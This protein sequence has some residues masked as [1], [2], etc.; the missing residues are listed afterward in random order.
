VVSI[1]FPEKKQY[2]NAHKSDHVWMEKSFWDS[3]DRFLPA[4]KNGF[5][6][7]FGYFLV[8]FG[9]LALF[10]LIYK[11]KNAFIAICFLIYTTLLLL[12]LFLGFVPMIDRYFFISVLLF[13]W[14]IGI[15]L[16]ALIDFLVQLRLPLRIP[17]RGIVTITM[18]TLIGLLAFNLKAV[19]LQEYRKVP[20]SVV[21]IRDWL[22]EHLTGEGHVFFDYLGGWDQYL[23]AYTDRVGLMRDSYSYSYFPPLRNLQPTSDKK[24]QLTMNGHVYIM[25]YEPK[26]I[27]LRGEKKYK[28]IYESAIRQYPDGNFYGTRHIRPS[29]VQPYLKSCSGNDR[30]CLI[31]ESEYMDSPVKMWRVYSNGDYEVFQPV[32]EGS[33]E[34]Q[35]E[36]ATNLFCSRFLS[37]EKGNTY[38]QTYPA[39]INSM[40]YSDAFDGTVGF[41]ENPNDAI[42]IPHQEFFSKAFGGNFTFSMWIL[43][44]SEKPNGEKNYSI[45]YKSKHDSTDS[46]WFYKS[47]MSGDYKFLIRDQ[48]KVHN[49]IRFPP[50]TVSGAGDKQWHQYVIVF[51]RK[52]GR[53]YAYKDGT[54]LTAQSLNEQ[55]KIKNKRPLIIGNNRRMG[56]DSWKGGIY[57]LCIWNRS[58]IEEEVKTG[59]FQTLKDAGR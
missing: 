48:N 14:I 24:I 15:G 26:Y 19:A 46:F 54:Q 56:G 6:A 28:H 40:K 7:D 45:F 30:N 57:N 16:S 51:D 49:S 27:V 9:L 22:N 43:D 1:F 8:F 42:V 31:L 4:F 23:H 35:L 29:Y 36:P 47:R 25:E 12:V 20:Q 52:K 38:A 3:W 33:A 44:Q 18:V 58:L 32:Y 50:P 10:F 13:S 37:N 2:F 55:A 21:E 41:F 34:V 17:Y 59:Y 5:I 11:R 39:I 53:A